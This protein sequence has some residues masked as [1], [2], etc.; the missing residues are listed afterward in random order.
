VV[1]SDA[2]GRYFTL[3]T[4][5]LGSLANAT[6]LYFRR[7]EVG[8]VASY[9]L[10]KDGQ[11][12]DVRVFVDAPYDQYV[13]PNTRFW[14]ASGI[15]LSLSASGLSVETQSVESI[16]IGGVAFETPASGPVLP[17]AEPDTV[18][19]LFSDR[20]AAFRPAAQDPQTYR[21]VFDQAVRGLA[22]GAPV[23]FRGIPIG[24]VV[25]VTAQLDPKTFAF[26][27]PVT[28]RVDPQR[29]GV[30]APTGESGVES[31]SRRELVD[32]LVSHGVRAQ[33]QT[34]NLLTGAL[35]V[36][37]DFFPD[38]QPATVDWSQQPPQL[39]TT[40]GTFE[41][42]EASLVRIIKKI[43]QIPFEGIGDELRNA[44]VEFD[45]TLVSAQG[46]LDSANTMI[47]PSSDLGERLDE[48]L[49]EVSGAAR[50]LRLLADY[51]ERHPEALIRGKTEEAR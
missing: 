50:A 47:E 29:F 8:E 13:T 5:D 36:A 27:V 48:T 45:R 12:L 15:D 40:P 42:I 1:T 31:T 34:G 17:P 30:A 2:P 33:L 41:A 23:E 43:D 19:T 46:T 16:L 28:V 21:L 9:Q 14:H 4:S 51:L 32:G 24:E 20:N 49:Q 25:D 18:F 37:F 22:A 35:L 3:T 7:L 11:S 26:S 44:I 38:A 10:A 39:P 6:P